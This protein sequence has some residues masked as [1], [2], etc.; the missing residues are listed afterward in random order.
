MPQ[1]STSCHASSLSRPRNACGSLPRYLVGV[2]EALNRL[3]DL[4]LHFCRFLNHVVELLRALGETVQ[5]SYAVVGH[6]LQPS[7]FKTRARL[8]VNLCLVADEIF[9]V[10]SLLW[11]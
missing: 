9:R 11:I 1:V 3:N 2:T 6:K 10:L 7:T 5:S 8:N 4:L